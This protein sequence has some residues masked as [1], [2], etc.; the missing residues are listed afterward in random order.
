MLSNAALSHMQQGDLATAHA[1]L[2]QAAKGGSADPKIAHNLALVEAMEAA[3][4]PKP[5]ATAAA[6]AP[7]RR[8]APAPSRT[9]AAPTQRAPPRQRR[10]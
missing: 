10:R 7:A 8:A 2:Q 5:V 9:A 6:P 4:A 1:L 3:A